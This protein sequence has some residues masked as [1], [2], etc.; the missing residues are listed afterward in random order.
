MAVFAVGMRT[1]LLQPG[2][3]TALPARSAGAWMVLPQAQVTRIE[4]AAAEAAFWMGRGESGTG[5]TLAQEGHLTRLPACSSG[6]LKVLEQGAQVTLIGTA[7]LLVAGRATWWGEGVAS[8]GLV[9]S[10]PPS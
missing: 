6:T 7:D 5:S 10:Y 1:G 8:R 9:P 4:P 3:R 2:Q